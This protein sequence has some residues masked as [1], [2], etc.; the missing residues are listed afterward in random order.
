M[1][2]RVIFQDLINPGGC[3]S[4]NRTQP[5]PCLPLFE[6]GAAVLSLARRKRDDGAAV[7]NGDR[8]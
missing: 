3:G 2:H 1:P 6:K 7:L 4:A 5:W 8:M